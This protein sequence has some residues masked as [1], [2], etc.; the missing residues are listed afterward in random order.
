MTGF[1]SHEVTTSLLNSTAQNQLSLTKSPPLGHLGFM[2]GRALVC[3]VAD[4]SSA[5]PAG[6][7][8]RLESELGLRVA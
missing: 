5:P 6:H 2:P 3:S 4:V 8:R 1:I 7:L